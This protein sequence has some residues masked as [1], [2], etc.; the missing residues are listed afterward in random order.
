MKEGKMKA[1]VLYGPGDVRIEET[2][3]PQIGD[4][5]I[6]IRIE[7]CGICPS[8]VRWYTGSRKGTYP[9]R[10]GHE[11]A[12]EVVEVGKDVKSYRPGDRVVADWRVVC[13]HC[14]YCRRG[15]N[16]YC[17]NFGSGVK[18]GFCEYGV[19]IETN[20][21]KIPDAVS[22]QEA[23]FTEPLACC[24]NGI[25]KNKIQLG[26]D[27]LVVGT[28]PIGLLH[29]QLAR[30]FGARVIACD[31]VDERL[32][33]AKEVGAHDIV[34][35]SKESDAL[36]KIKELT[37]GRGADSVIVAV[38]STKAI[39]FGIKAAGIQGKI[40][41]FAGS[42][43]PTTFNLD[44]NEIHYKELSVIGSHDFTPHHF[45]VALKMVE[46]GMVKVKPLISHEF[47][48]E[49]IQKGFDTVVNREGLKVII[50]IKRQE[51]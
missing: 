24:I 16:N 23:C 44:P 2:D 9:R 5:S 7:Y 26:D 32:E 25:S 31:L 47:P 18:G 10:T 14:Y 11:W 15:I 29:V 42:Y 37:N 41:I 43:P 27:V 28:G 1:A 40:N 39:E 51:G 30:N 38:G 36:E 3:I 34:N 4:S 33:V 21:R 46:F 22:Y 35:S 12:G 45:T 50:R 48:L 49:E 20:L 19:A 8:D 13:G 6:L 17:S